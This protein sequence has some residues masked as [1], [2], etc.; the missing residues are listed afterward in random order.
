MN[1]DVSVQSFDSVTDGAN[2][3]MLKKAIGQSSHGKRSKSPLSPSSP[4][5]GI[6][7]EI[8]SFANPTTP[9]AIINM[10]QNMT[11]RLLLQD[12]P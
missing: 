1:R 5:E 2:R 11:S 8:M 4:T 7:E 12:K 9:F 3:A 6:K 10:F